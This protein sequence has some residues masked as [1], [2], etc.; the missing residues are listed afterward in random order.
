MQL[1]T[2][3]AASII[4]AESIKK[5]DVVTLTR[6]IRQLAQVVLTAPPTKASKLKGLKSTV[7]DLKTKSDR[8]SLLLANKVKDEKSFIETI[9]LFAGL[10]EACLRIE[11]YIATMDAAGK[12]VA[13]NKAKQQL[14][15]DS[16]DINGSAPTPQ[17]TT[18]PPNT[19]S[20]VQLSPT[21]GNDNNSED[22]EPLNPIL[23]T[24]E[25]FLGA[26]AQKYRSYMKE[27]LSGTNKL[28]KDTA[29]VA[30]RKVI[31]ATGTKVTEIISK[32]ARQTIPLQTLKL[33]VD[34]FNV[35]LPLLL[36]VAARIKA[37]RTNLGSSTMAQLKTALGAPEN[38]PQP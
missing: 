37:Y 21:S 38:Q 23:Q 31:A 15:K 27:C 34:D 7:I 6:I 16:K 22:T 24:V 12:I 5:S 26:D 30:F 17:T 10:T 2:Q 9:S 28:S 33:T 18:T 13:E 32:Q 11:D 20:G 19:P 8:F 14:E 4:L 25:S 29:T 35:L 3:R 1:T 36:P